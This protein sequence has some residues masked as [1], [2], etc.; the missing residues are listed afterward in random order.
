MNPWVL[1]QWILLGILVIPTVH[2]I[3]IRKRSRFHSA[4]A[5]IALSCFVWAFGQHAVNTVYLYIGNERLYFGSVLLCYAGM[6]AL[7]P[8]CLYV[9][10]CY[11]GKF[12]HYASNRKVTLIFGIGAFFY[13]VVLTSRWQ[14]LYYTAFSL[15][16]RS[17]GILFY[18]FT[19]W[20]YCCFAYTAVTVQ[21]YQWDGNRRTSLLYLL[22][23]L[24][25]VI[26]NTA[27]MILAKP[28]YDF[29]V[30]ACLLVHISCYL[31]IYLHH[32]ISLIPVAEKKVFDDMLS[33][34]MIEDD[35]GAVLYKNT[36]AA[37]L[38][39]EICWPEDGASVVYTD[40]VYKA[41]NNHV[42]G[43]VI[44]T[45]TDISEYE[46]ALRQLNEKNSAMVEL[47]KKL[48]KQTETL[49]QK[50]SSADRIAAEKRRVEIMTALSREVEGMLYQ[51]KSDTMREIENPVN[52]EISSCLLSC[53]K[54]LNA[55]RQIISEYNQPS[56]R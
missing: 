23:I 18:L 10:W 31:Q 6:C 4:Y 21:R 12:I 32:P 43:T 7:G 45:L 56:Q 13:A 15:S 26:A 27:D 49:N 50:A 46:Q 37:G 40:S 51:L 14:P 47:Q 16:G 35:T 25:P 52:E 36:R 19:A 44:R 5:I 53:D 30:L 42:R 17:Y 48:A 1:T 38:P 34:V 9:S 2:F 20:S 39:E 55:V 41:S 24:P 8:A 54:I 28:L 29:T 33:P 11:C 3:L 22:C